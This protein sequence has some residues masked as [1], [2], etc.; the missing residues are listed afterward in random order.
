MDRKL[1]KEIGKRLRRLRKS[2][3]LT[4]AELAERLS[5]SQNYLSELE[6][7]NCRLTSELYVKLYGILGV[8]PNTLI[9]GRIE[10]LHRSPS[11]ALV[12]GSEPDIPEDG[13]CED[14]AIYGEE[15]DDGD[16]GDESV[17]DFLGWFETLE[18]RRREQVSSLCESLRSVME[19]W[20]N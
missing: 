7:G 13:D 20:S 6:N 2:L 19:K 11:L 9:L 1:T 15:D 10:D 16:D 5:I 12:C 14:N 8:S 3:G 18:G 17:L 4:Q